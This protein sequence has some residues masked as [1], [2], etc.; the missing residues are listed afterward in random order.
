MSSQAQEE[1]EREMLKRVLLRKTAPHFR[2]DFRIKAMLSMVSR[3]L[4]TS[5][6]ESP[7]MTRIERLERTVKELK[8]KKEVEIPSKADLVYLKF[9]DE[10]EKEHFGKIVAIDVNSE[11]IVGI[12][13]SILEA[14][15]KAEEKTHEKQFS[16]RRVGFHFV[17]RL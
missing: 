5:E 13:D 6:E 8:R 14:Y 11:S 15:K 9:K 17:H 10:L 12:G 1:I 16:Y 2:D 3:F 4:I 7:I